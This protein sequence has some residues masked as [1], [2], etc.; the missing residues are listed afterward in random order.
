MS[1]VNARLRLGGA[2][3]R[4]TAQPFQLRM[5]A[6]LQRLLPFFLRV[7]VQLLGL[8][9]RAVIPFHAERAIFVSAVQFHHFVRDVLQEITIVAD[10]HARKRRVPQNGFKPL[11]P[12]KVQMIGG[13]IEKQDVRRLHQGLGDGQTFAPATRQ[14]RGLR[15]K[16]G[17][18]RAAQRL[19]KARRAFSFG[20]RRSLQSALNDR[21]NRHTRSKFRNL[22]DVAQPRSFADRHIPAVR[23]DAPIQ[24]LQQRRFP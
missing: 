19:R 4:P 8:Q 1:L 15:I 17:N 21:A 12:G 23:L 11:N 2:R 20:N 14:C 13:L 6:V 22:R 18:S 3:F 7:Q 9:E 16:I 24:H 10:H 5:H